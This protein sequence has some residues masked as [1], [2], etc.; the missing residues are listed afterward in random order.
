MRKRIVIIE[1]N[2]AIRK[3]LYDILAT[4]ERYEVINQYGACEDA[5]ANLS[6][7]KPDVVLMDIELPGMSGIEGT[8][9]IK[10]LLPTC[11]VLIITVYEDSEKV[12][13][14]LC[15]GADGYIVKNSNIT[16]IAQNIDEAIDGGAPM[17]LSIAR[18]VVKSFQQQSINPL[19]ERETVILQSIAEGKSYSKIALDLFI[20]KETVR[21]HIKNI[22]RKLKVTSKADALKIANT[23]KWFGRF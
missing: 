12:F 23:N 13:K 4:I 20:S 19:S 9:Q 17:S 15:A 10:N 22:Y 21:T 5:I 6:E 11:I 7:D 8:L 2:S 3:G 14:S 16:T 1:D 18:M